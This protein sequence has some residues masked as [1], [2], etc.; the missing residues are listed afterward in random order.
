MVIFN[1]VNSFFETQNQSTTFLQY[2]I[3]KSLSNKFFLN[4]NLLYT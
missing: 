4:I 3:D 1:D 2:L